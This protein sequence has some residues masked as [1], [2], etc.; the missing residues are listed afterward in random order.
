MAPGLRIAGVLSPPFGFDRDPA[1]VEAVVSEVRALRPDVLFVALGAPRQERF[2][3]AHGARLGA[4]VLFPVG[5]AID[6]AAGLVKRAPGFVQLAGGEWLWRLAQ[7][8]RRLGR[9]YL[10]EDP[11]FLRLAAGAL[12]ERRRQRGL[13]LPVALPPAS[14]PQRSAGGEEA[15]ISSTLPPDWNGIP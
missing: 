2:V 1:Q 14:L 4:R 10:L 3:L 11:V 15:A 5:A 12:L 8:P 7:E 13:A 6:M 9:R